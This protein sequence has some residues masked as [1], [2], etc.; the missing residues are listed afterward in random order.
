MFIES[1]LSLGMVLQKNLPS[2][3]ANLGVFCSFIFI[4][5]IYYYYDIIIYTQGKDLNRTEW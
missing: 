5:D 3:P 1:L 2:T 4:Y